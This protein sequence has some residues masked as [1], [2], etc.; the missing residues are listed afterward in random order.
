MDL[1]KLL[2]GYYMSNSSRNWF[3]GFLDKCVEGKDVFS[4]DGKG[5]GNP[6]MSREEADLRLALFDGEVEPTLEIE[7]QLAQ[8]EAMRWPKSKKCQA[9]VWELMEKIKDKQ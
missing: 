9:R 6:I 8:L 5:Q 7:L 1:V 2:Q 4:I 3:V